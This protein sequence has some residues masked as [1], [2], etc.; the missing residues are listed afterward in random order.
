MYSNITDPNL[1][2]NKLLYR[3]A[4]IANSNTSYWSSNGSKVISRP[5]ALRNLNRG[6]TTK[7]CLH[8]HTWAQHNWA[9]P[10]DLQSLMIDRARRVRNTYDYVRVAYSGG[11]DSQAILTQFKDAGLEPN[12]IFFWTFISDADTKYSTNY[13]IQRAVIDHIPTLR[14]WFPTT[15]FTNLE[16][17]LQQL[18]VLRSLS[19][20]YN[21][22]S[23]YGSGIRTLPTALA[24]CCFKD[25]DIKNSITLTGADKPRVD[26][27]NGNWYAYFVDTACLDTWGHGV[28]GFY[29]ADDPSIHIAQCHAIKNLIEKQNFTSRQEILRFQ[30]SK[31]AAIRHSINSALCRPPVFDD[32]AVLGKKTTR[33]MPDPGESQP[34]VYLLNRT[35][36]TT[37]TG[38]EILN[39]W[40]QSKKDFSTYI[41]MDH[42]TSIFGSFYN[43][44]TGTVHTVDQLFPQGWNL[45]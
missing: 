40:A 6:Q 33:T 35:L 1:S 19:P 20:V 11:V 17:N 36:R 26:Y 7:F 42:N 2:H 21:N 31:V 28:E 34:K 30:N 24:L 38:Q 39:A 37:S 15:K 14:R 25:F 27:I 23:V 10:K 9:K 3:M 29:Y 44:N 41:G 16:F 45:N 8:D 13:E 18:Q 4:T 22:F 32:I 5:Q 12:E 43:L